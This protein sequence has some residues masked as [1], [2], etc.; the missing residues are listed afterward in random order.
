MILKLLL[1]RQLTPP[2][3]H[4]LFLHLIS[5]LSFKDIVRILLVN[6]RYTN[7]HLPLFVAVTCFCWG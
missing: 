5:A 1:N 3:H 6:M 4:I 2:P 7:I